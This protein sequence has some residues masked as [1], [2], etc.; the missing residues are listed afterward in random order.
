MAYPRGLLSEGEDVVLDLHPHGKALI[1]PLALV[2]IVIGLGS[3]LAAVAPAGSA[4][5]PLQLAVLVVAL[6]LLSMFSL[7]PF[8]RWQATHYVITNRRIVL[9]SGILSRRGRD[10]PLN[11]VNDVSFEHGLL[12]RLLRTGSLTVESAGERGQLVLTDVPRVER[13]QHTIYE[14]VQQHEL[15]RDRDENDG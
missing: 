14:L 3:F 11:R 12:E 13:V 10:I 15:R 4:H 6:A 7:R 5:R 9:R 1:V 2:P 8:L